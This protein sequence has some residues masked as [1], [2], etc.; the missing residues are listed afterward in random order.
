M[1]MRLSNGVFS[2]P[3]VT[4]LVDTDH[5]TGAASL[6]AK[7][8]QP[9]SALQGSA[10]TAL[11]GGLDRATQFTLVPGRIH[12]ITQTN[13]GTEITI[14]QAG[15]GYTVLSAAQGL[16]IPG[17]RALPVS[18]LATGFSALMA[19]CPAARADLADL[20]GL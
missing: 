3:S 12:T 13:R 6:D 17:A 11:V 2:G 18:G 7:A 8:S 14:V 16:G 19:A 5:G 10:C 9:W 4:V 20:C 15:F 1:E